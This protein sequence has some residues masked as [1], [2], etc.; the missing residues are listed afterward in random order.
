MFRIGAVYIYATNK[1]KQNIAIHQKNT[2]CASGPS[3]SVSPPLTVV[4]SGNMNLEQ[5][6]ERRGNPETETTEQKHDDENMNTS[7][8][9]GKRQHQI[10]DMYQ[11]PS[12]QNMLDTDV[13]GWVGG[14]CLLRIKR[15]DVHRAINQLHVRPMGPAV[16]F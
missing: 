4:F 7:L 2:E 1:K 16:F 9:M 11:G 15:D 10:N 13:A 5:K 3:F 8:S 14:Y 12:E 6:Q